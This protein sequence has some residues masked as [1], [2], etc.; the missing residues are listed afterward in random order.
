MPVARPKACAAC[1]RPLNDA[2]V[3]AAG[4]K[5]LGASTEQSDSQC[6]SSPFARVGVFNGKRRA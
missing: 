2:G 3:R 1:G 4:E 5:N 6:F